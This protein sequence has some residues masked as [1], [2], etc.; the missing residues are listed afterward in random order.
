MKPRTRSPRDNSDSESFAAAGLLYILG[1]V[2]LPGYALYALAA[3]RAGRTDPRQTIL[4]YA[5]L[6]LWCIAIIAALWWADGHGLGAWVVTH[7]PPWLR[8]R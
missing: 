4:V 8:G 1:L 6:S 7:A 2:T 3:T 5:V